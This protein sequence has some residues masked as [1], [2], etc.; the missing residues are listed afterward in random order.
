VQAYTFRLTLTDE[1]SNRLMPERPPRY[2]RDIYVRMRNRWGLGGRIPNGKLHWNTSNLPGGNWSY[3]EADWEARAEI[4]RRHLD[5]A[6]GFLWFLQNDEAVPVQLREK[7]QRY[8]LARDEYT[9]NAHV[10]WEMYVREARRLVGRSVFTEHDGTI[11]PGL[12]RAPVHDDSIAVTEWG[13]DSHS[14]SEEMVPGS[15]REGKLLLTELSRPGQVPYRCLLPRDLDNL[16]VPV[17]LSA[18]HVGWGAIR[19]EPTWMHIGESAGAAAAL[20][21]VTQTPVGNISVDALQRKLVESGVMISF[22]NEFDMDSKAR[23]AGAV[24]YFG[25]KGFF[26]SYDALPESPLDEKTAN[27]WISIVAARL[28]EPPTHAAPVR[29][30]ERYPAPGSTGPVSSEAFR[31]SLTSAFQGSPRLLE[32]I[33]SHWPEHKTGVCEWTRGEACLFFYDL[34]GFA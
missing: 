17:C 26:A 21:Q 4:T 24:Q 15:R 1:P 10:P 29:W 3:P 16:L 7:A 19:L 6:I 2:D 11:G 25:A 5:H 18:T 30:A 20:S 12:C 8:G 23:W 28:T 27:V 34:A 14:V 22:F 31:H 32:V 13:M 9:D 33:E